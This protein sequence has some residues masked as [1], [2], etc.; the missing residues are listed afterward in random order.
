MPVKRQARV[1]MAIGENLLWEILVE[2]HQV[3][4]L[5]QLQAEEQ[6]KD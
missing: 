6:D 5:T 3:L 1:F 4:I 2:Q